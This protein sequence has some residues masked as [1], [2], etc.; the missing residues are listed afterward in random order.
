[1]HLLDAVTHSPN[2]TQREL[3]K[4]IGVALG[5]TNLML[6]RLVKKGYIKVINTQRNR[7]RY[8]IT[9]QGILEKTRLTYEYIHYSLQLYGGVRHF[10][11][12]RLGALAQAGHRQILLCGSDE[13]AEIAFLTARETGLTIVG[14][15]DLTSTRPSLLGYPVQSLEAVQTLIYDQVVVTALREPAAV[16]AALVERGVAPDRIIH[17]GDSRPTVPAER[18]LVAATEP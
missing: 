12:E 14:I 13:M 4:R 5:L 7:I 8:L 11:R 18:V 9:P 6:R 17:L 2:V 16:V 3:S 15:V 1:M 10:L